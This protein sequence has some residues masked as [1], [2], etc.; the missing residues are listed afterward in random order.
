MNKVMGAAVLAGHGLIHLIGFVV[1]WQLAVV[2][3]FA[4]R[5]TAL[6]GALALGD[7]GARLIGAAWLVLGVGFVLAAVVTWRGT[8]QAAGLTAVLAAASI[9]VCVLGLPETVAGIVV[10]IAILAVLGWTTIGRTSTGVGAG[11]SAGLRA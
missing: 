5:T 6:G 8:R 11:A 7:V 2:D 9:I 10:N 1:L 3:G 4:Y